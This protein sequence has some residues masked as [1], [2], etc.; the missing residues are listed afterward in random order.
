MTK[1]TECCLPFPPPVSLC[2]NASYCWRFCLLAVI[3]PAFQQLA[4]IYVVL[5]QILHH[6]T[7]AS[8]GRL[9]WYDTNRQC[10]EI[11]KQ[12]P[13]YRTRSVTLPRSEPLPTT[14]GHYTI[15]CKK[16][17]LRSWRWA[18][19]C[20]EHVELI[21]EINKISYCCISF[22]FQYYFTYIDDAR[23]NTNRVKKLNEWEPC[24]SRRTVG[25]PRLRWL[26]QV[27]ED[28]KKMKLERE[29]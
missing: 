29:L 24:S 4:D 27:E 13:S 9:L 20:P 22:G 23:S 3:F 16:S 8:S 19:V 25:R 10:R 15:R 17:V 26:D 18:K 14:T 11:I 5:L 28:L 7:I 1:I 12:L 6:I 2:G 21:L